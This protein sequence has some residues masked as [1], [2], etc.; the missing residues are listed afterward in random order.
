MPDTSP[1]AIQT[2]IDK[3]PDI[4]AEVVR[5][6][7]ALVTSQLRGLALKAKQNPSLTAEQALTQA[8]DS[9]E[10]SAATLIEKLEATLPKARRSKATST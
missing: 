1:S 7:F 6:Q 3:N 5:R 9:I 2:K 10:V 4:F 8:A